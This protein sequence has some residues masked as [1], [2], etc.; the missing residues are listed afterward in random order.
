MWELFPEWLARGTEDAVNFY[1]A[2]VFV[3]AVVN[4]VFEDLRWRT[5]NIPIT[6]GTYG[7][8]DGKSNKPFSNLLKKTQA[9]TRLSFIFPIHCVMNI[10][11]G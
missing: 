7:R 5:T 3:N 9:Q 6:N 10:S 11:Q 4:E 8:R 1:S 2:G